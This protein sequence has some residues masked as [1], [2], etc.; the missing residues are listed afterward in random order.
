MAFYT[1]GN[2]VNSPDYEHRAVKMTKEM[3]NNYA[4]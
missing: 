2:L 4:K 3:E 1:M